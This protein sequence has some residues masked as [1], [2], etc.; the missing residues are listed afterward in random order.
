M[1]VPV[2]GLIVTGKDALA[3]FSIF[4]GTL[5]MW[6]PDATLYIFTDSDTRAAL[7]EIKFKGAI[8][9]MTAMDSY[10]GLTRKE[11]EKTPGHLY[12][13]LFKDYTYEKANV[14]DWIFESEPQLADSQDG[15]W[16]LDADIC[17]F[18]P[19]PKVPASST[20][21]LSPHYIQLKDE[22][23]YGKYNAGFLWLNDPLLVQ[24]WRTLGVKSR[25]FE[26]A[27]LEDLASRAGTGLYEF[28]IQVNFGW[29][30]MFQGR[31]SYQDVQRQFSVSQNGIQFMGLPIQSFHTHF[32]ETDSVTG[33]FN[34]WLRELLKPFSD[35]APLNGLLSLISYQRSP[36]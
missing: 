26:Q 25:F 6:H 27:A 22:A 20:L 29:W 9:L 21:A 24:A 11:M 8:N 19:L 17:H 16:F 18:A 35:K 13:T 12:D 31:A 32:H 2:I 15:V 3:D 34:R 4:C 23:L 33:L 14:L 1:S 36:S 5:E 30:R 10:R 7:T 28:P